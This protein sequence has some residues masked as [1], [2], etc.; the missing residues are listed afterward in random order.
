MQTLNA[1]ALIDRLRAADG[2]LDRDA[3]RAVLPYGDAFLFVDRITRLTL[4]DVEATFR[5]PLDAPYALAH[6]RHTPIMPGVLTGEGMVQAGTLLIRYRLDMSPDL[7]ILVSQVERA[8]FAASA[9]PGDT[10]T[11]TVTLKKVAAYGARLV[12][13]AKVGDVVVCDA[14]LCV[15]FIDRPR[16]QQATART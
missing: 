9:V 5:I 2:S 8:V 10:L 4:D 14:Q 7:D 6:F 3:V 15:V 13:R 11:Y 16:L 12:A 1:T